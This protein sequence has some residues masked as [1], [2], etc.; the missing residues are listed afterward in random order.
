[1]HTD[2]DARRPAIA[3]SGTI[4]NPCLSVCIRGSILFALELALLC[5]LLQTSIAGKALALPF[6]FSLFS[7]DGAVAHMHVLMIN[8][9]GRRERNYQ[10]HLLHVQALLQVLEHAGA[11]PDHVS[12]FSSDGDD[13]APDLAVSETEDPNFWLLRGTSLDGAL[14][15]PIT[16]ANSVVPGMRLYPAT[17]SGLR[18][19]FEAAGRRLR[20]G[21]TLL[22]YVTDHGSK[23]AADLTDNRITLWGKDESLSVHELKDLLA[24]LKPGV[25]VVAL[26][27]QCYSGAFANLSY[28]RGAEALPDGQVCGYFSSTADRP[29][30]GCYPENRGKD[31]VGHSFH[32]IRAL[33][34]SASFPAAHDTVLVTD[35]TPDVP[36]RTSDL[37]LEDL[38]RRSAQRKGQ[39]LPAAVDALLS[40][41]WRDKAAWEPEIRLLDRIAHA[42][43]YFSP[44]S[45]AEL[46]AQSTLLPDVSDKLKTYADSWDSALANLAQQNLQRFLLAESAWPPRLVP[47]QLQQADPAALRALTVSL[48]ANLGAFTRADTITDTRLGVLREKAEAAAAASYRMHVRLGV[49]LR[50]RAV[51]TSIAG[52][53]YV[54]QYASDAERQAFE[55]LRRCENVRLGDPGPGT[56]QLATADPFPSYDEE[57][58]V[59]Q[60][61]SPAWMGIRYKQ[62]SP[63]DRARLRLG[64]GA[65]AVVAV[66]PDSPAQRA[67]LA[68]G[69]F[70]LGPPGAP[71]TEPNQIREWT[72]LSA[73]HERAPLLVLRGN[74]RRRIALVPEPLPLVWP[75]LPAPPKVGAVAPRLQVE[76]YRGAAPRTLADGKPH[77]LFFWATWCAP[78]K[79]SL[80]EVLAF[81]QQ[82]HVQVIAVTDE[83]R[84]QLDTFFAHFST[85][86]PETV[87][88]DEYR[89]AFLAY[90][91][92][93]T[94][95]FVFIDGDGTVRGYTSGYTADKG[96]GVTGWAWGERTPAATAPH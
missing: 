27:S 54:S 93:G 55:A 9:G 31:N 48:L 87:A 49:V 23:N 86:F 33:E 35:R 78:C 76:A 13:P 77:L 44:R 72:M 38:L 96:I 68:V 16:Y 81:E 4:E 7:R 11:R 47:V 73:V 75:D 14:G 74:R 40:E 64:D 5:T 3:S 29:A 70:V 60:D 57:V 52:R 30:Y 63:N 91:V 71:F 83:L 66:Y 84:E 69:D 24:L 46:D 39:T 85:G 88:M 21:D 82:R 67:G 53:L 80:P 34:S 28:D 41:A 92:S 10:S 22:V 2:V 89:R 58:K 65:A 95:T 6:P 50:L 19:W 15:T 20:R 18:T 26:M 36:L 45:L 1:M 43:G 42:V 62:A 79:A 94:P 25:R 17:K 12:I 51:L 61:A 56:T 59:A 32:F 37:Y 8:G 90:G